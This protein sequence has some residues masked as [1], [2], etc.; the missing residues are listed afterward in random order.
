MSEQLRD[1]V[2]RIEE[3]GREL[4]LDYYPVD[5]ELVPESFMME[6]AVQLKNI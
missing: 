3:L 2:A 4:G 1:Y 5:F 6:V